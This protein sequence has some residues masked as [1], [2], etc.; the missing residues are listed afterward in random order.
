MLLSTGEQISV[1][2]HGH[3]DPGPRGARRSASPAADRPRSPTASTPRRGS[4]TS[5][6]SGCSQALND[7]KIVIVAGFQ[8]IDEDYNITTL[9][10]GGSDTTAVARWPRSWGPTPAR[11]T[12]TSTAS[13]RPTRAAC[14]RPGRS[15]GSATTK[16]SSWP[17]SAPGA[18]TALDRVRQEVRRADPC[19][20][21]VLR[22]AGDL[23]RRRDDA[24]RLGVTGH[25]RG[26]GQ[27]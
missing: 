17:A 13:T 21:L 16:C 24:R 12:P 23:D 7:G 4:A 8:G 6:P 9:G 15:I 2:A 19:A 11:S 1:D 5:R 18:C 14:P 27:G 20:E 25:R 10:R 26:P 22:R 3:G